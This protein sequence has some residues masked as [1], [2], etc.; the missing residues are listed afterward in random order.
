MIDR[1]SEGAGG[2]DYATDPEAAVE[3]LSIGAEAH[4]V[5]V[6]D[7]LLRDPGALVDFAAEQAQFSP[8][9][10]AGNF[11]PGVRAPAP[12]A[13][14]A[15]LYAALAPVLRQ[16][17]GV[18]TEGR[19]KA[20]CALSLATLEPERL[21]L[22]QRLPHLDTTD[23]RQFAVLHYLCDPRHGGTAFYRHRS[24][25]FE[26]ID[27]ARAPAYFAALNAE[28]EAQGPPSPGY[29][30]GSTPLFEQ[31]ARVEARFNRVVIYRSQM[32]HSGLIDPVSG[33]AAD[34]RVG[35]LTANAFF[36]FEH[37]GEG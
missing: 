32:L 34:P 3:V 4:R 22:A 26:A 8:L 5:V 24:T 15:T 11:Y 35:R 21:N 36:T 2:P 16:V 31:T 6:V 25:G 9:R 19:F 12:Q 14:A 33:L 23:P 29:V 18:D 13:Y 17:F 30:T 27:E 28:I 1:P 7:G 10:E 20:S 37:A